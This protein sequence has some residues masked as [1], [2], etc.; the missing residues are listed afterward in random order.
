LSQWKVRLVLLLVLGLLVT[1]AGLLEHGALPAWPAATAEQ[2]DLPVERPQEPGPGGFVDVT[3][4]CGVDFTYRNGEE[5]GHSAILQSLGGG[6]GLLDYDGDGLLDIFVI[7]GGFFDGPDKKQIKG[8]P[9]R[10]YRNLGGM[11]FRD[12]TREAGLGPLSFY[13]HGCAV[14]DYDGD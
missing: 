2:A 11:K 10:L 3:R 5:A 6:V 7:G 1:G 8:H 14:G 13:S 12:V 9:C 4:D